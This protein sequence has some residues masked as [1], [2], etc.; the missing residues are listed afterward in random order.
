MA[1]AEE[2]KHLAETVRA[3]ARMAESQILQ[4]EWENLAECYIR[5]AEQT[6]E[7]E[8]LDPVR[9]PIIGDPIMGILG[10]YRR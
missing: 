6:E 10:G 8:P 2:Y 9:D 1:R 5:I 7:N 3:R 4:I